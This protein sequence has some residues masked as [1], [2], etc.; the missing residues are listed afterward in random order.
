MTSRALAKY[1]APGLTRSA[2][3]GSVSIDLPKNM[4]LRITPKNLARLQTLT[5][6]LAL[7]EA[8]LKDEAGAALDGALLTIRSFV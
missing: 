5:Q 7:E 1:A 3:D 6:R 8:A 2:R 4:G